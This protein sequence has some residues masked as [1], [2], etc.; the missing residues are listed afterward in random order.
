MFLARKP[1]IFFSKAFVSP[2]LVEGH[3]QGRWRWGW[4]KA[5]LVVLQHGTGVLLLLPPHRSPGRRGEGRRG[6]GRRLLVQGIVLSSCFLGSCHL[7]VLPTLWTLGI[8]VGKDVRPRI[9]DT[10]SHVS[11]GILREWTALPRRPDD[12]WNRVLGPLSP[13][14]LEVS[15]RMGCSWDGLETP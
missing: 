5:A 12:H 14:S 2:P 9:W 7:S 4:S 1:S 13:L 3:L 6:E 11:L 8:L 15:G 10:T